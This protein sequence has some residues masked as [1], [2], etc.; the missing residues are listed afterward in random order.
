MRLRALIK[1]VNTFNEREI[2]MNVN[3]KLNGDELVFEIEG[4]IDSSTAP[5]LYDEVNRS[6]DGI[7]SLIFDFSKVDYI[8]SAGLRVLLAAYKIMS[9][10]GKM[11]ICNANEN[12]MDIF[13]ITGF[14]N[15]LTIK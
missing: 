6:L 4:N 9:K 13:Q 12:V 14:T 7:K 10:Q 15:F 3:K 1:A 2:I 8:S 11:V 5:A